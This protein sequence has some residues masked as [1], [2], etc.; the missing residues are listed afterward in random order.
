MPSK[1]NPNKLTI[2]AVRYK[3]NG[4]ID[5]IAKELHDKLLLPKKHC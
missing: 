5:R 2:E 1:N 4:H 3:L